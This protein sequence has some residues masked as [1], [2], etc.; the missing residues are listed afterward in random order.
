MKLLLA[1]LIFF[2]IEGESQIK[3]KSNIQTS[4][5][6]SNLDCKSITCFGS[7]NC[8][9][10]PAKNIS[11][12]IPVTQKAQK[13]VDV[14]RQSLNFTDDNENYTLANGTWNLNMTSSDHCF[15]L[16]SV[17]LPLSVLFIV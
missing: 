10:I 6:S 16:F 5:S 9:T 12:C 14:I 11:K 8:T 15:S 7:A 2:S 4:S 13:I 1:F 3:S 17:I